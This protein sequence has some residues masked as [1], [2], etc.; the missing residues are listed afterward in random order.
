MSTAASPC[1]GQEGWGICGVGLIDNAAERAK[2]EGMAAQDGLYTLSLF[3]PRGEPTSSVVGAIVEY[4]FAPADPAAV[5]AR[6]C[7][8]AIRIVSMTI[9]EGGYN[10]DE[11]TGGFRLDAPDIAH[12]LA[13]PE[14][15]RTVFGFIVEALARRRAGGLPAFTVLSC[16][17]LQHNGEVAPRRVLAFAGARDPEL[18]DW[19]DGRRR[20]S[21]TAWSTASRPR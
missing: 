3:P 14:A 8:P 17:N 18:A 1:P 16:D 13:H 19:I 21:P 2:A 6:L 12:D 11:A 9:T 15:P 20:P 5:L 4:L 10:I 7:D